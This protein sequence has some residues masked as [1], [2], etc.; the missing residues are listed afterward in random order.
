MIRLCMNRIFSR[1]L[2]LAIS[3]FGLFFVTIL[4]PVPSCD[5]EKVYVDI[6]SPFMRKIPVAVPEPHVE[7][8]TFED[9]VAARNITRI[10]AADLEFMGF[11]SVP[12]PGLYR[13][14]DMP[15]KDYPADY[16]VKSRMQHRGN[17]LVME[18]RLIETATGKLAAGVKYSA[19]MQDQR[20]LA[21]RFAE[22]VVRAIT[23]EGGLRLSRIGFVGTRGT[24]REVYS[25]DFDGHNVRKETSLHTIVLS[26]R[27]SPDGRFIAF[28]SYRSG[29]PCLYIKDLKTGRISRSACYKGS[30]IAH[31]WHP[32]SRK[33]AITLSRDGSPDI[34]LVT[35]SGKI[36]KRLTWGRS[37]NIS[38]SWSP[39]GSELVFVSDRAGVPQLY[40]LNAGSGSVR[41]LIFTGVYSTD[42]QWSPRGDRIVFS[43]RVNGK[44]Q[45]FT[46]PAR[47]GEPEQLTFSDSNEN[48]SWSP[49]G[50][51]ILFTRTQ[52]NGRKCLYVMYLNGA[53]KRRLLEF[54]NS[55]AMGFWGP[56][57]FMN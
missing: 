53:G 21:H 33:L 12:D 30:N 54:G 34:Y 23:G 25:A 39:D 20:I 43:A 41:R 29:R 13:S 3:A 57:R 38:P 32:G 44:F 11:F 22:K 10:L 19:N 31:S 55:A 50:R 46:V 16:V 1:K 26:P 49:D 8:G 18:F 45:I 15:L 9:R 48:P 6:T 36:I 4:G 5:A 40:I 37:I 24:N 52:A 14:P 56:N 2:L 42:P 35:L 17:E 47:G 27:Y 28:T 51:Q 7:G